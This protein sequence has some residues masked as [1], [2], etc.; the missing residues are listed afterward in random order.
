[1]RCVTI[2]QLFTYPAIDIN[3]NNYCYH[4][5]SVYII[6]NLRIVGNGYAF[7]FISF[8]ALQLNYYILFTCSS[9]SIFYIDATVRFTAPD[10]I[11]RFI[12]Y[13]CRVSDEFPVRFSNLKTVRFE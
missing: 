9:S 5:R 10:C 4:R 13:P 7:V 1:M 3:Y 11:G 2:L 6:K 8:C 12:W